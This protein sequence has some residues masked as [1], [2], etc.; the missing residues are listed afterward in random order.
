MHMDRITNKTKV[1]SCLLALGI[2]FFMAACGSPSTTASTSTPTA[3]PTTAPTVAPT[4]AP[5]EA[6]TAAPTEAP[7]TAPSGGNSVSIVNFAF[8]PASLTVKV[9]TKV[10]WTNNDSVGH[11]VTADGGAFDSQTVG[12]NN[13]FSFTFTKAGTYTYHCAIHP[14]MTATIIVQ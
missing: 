6:P 9:G 13:S 5:T 3:A 12:P 8:S 7:T 2:L 4:T 1:W 11:T 10:T 14:Y